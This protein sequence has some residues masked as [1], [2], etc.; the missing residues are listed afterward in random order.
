MLTK[1]R[2]FLDYLEENI[3]VDLC[4]CADKLHIASLKFEPVD[5]LPLI[6]SYPLPKDSPFKPF[7]HGETFD[8][9]EK[10]LFNQFLSS[11]DISIY[12]NKDVKSDLPC[13]I[14][15]DFGCVLI[16]SMFGANIEQVENNPPWVRN[17]SPLSYQQILAVDTGDFSKGWI[18][19]VAQ[20]YK[21]YRDVL[22][23]YPRL[24]SVT[25]ITLPD[26]QGPIDN[27][28]LLRGSELFLEI[29]TQRDDFLAAM[30]KVTDA[31]I[32]LAEY[33]KPLISERIEGVSH[34]HSFPLLGQMLIRC[35]TAIMLSPQMYAELIGPYDEKVLAALGGGIHSCGNVDG[36]VEEFLSLKLAKCFDYG[37]SEL[38]D[39]RTAYNAAKAKKIAI[40]RIAVTE[41]QLVDRKVMDEFPTGVSLL[42]RAESKEQACEVVGKY[43]GI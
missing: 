22:Q 27:L 40:T 21:F 28:E 39:V 6:A 34:Q 37:Q 30:E 17:Q 7:A 14:R 24:Q 11:F 33:F 43:K 10:M 9:P 1:L 38:N 13:S 23:D 4:I 5:R 35:D 41:D 2:E 36:I 8:N 32:R 16:A 20:R 42:F 19:R 18:P 31:Q 15:A 26:L 29:Y 3:D 12:H 25:S